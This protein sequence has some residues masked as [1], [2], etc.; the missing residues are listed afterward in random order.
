MGDCGGL[1]IWVRT[2]SEILNGCKH[3]LNFVRDKLRY[4]PDADQAVAY[5]RD[6]NPDYVPEHLAE[7][8]PGSLPSATRLDPEADG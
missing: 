6:R 5:L 7:P 2:W 4:D 8:G 1:R 3:R